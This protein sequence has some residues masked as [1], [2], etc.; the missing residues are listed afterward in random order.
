M[1]INEVEKLTGL[2][3]K[4]IR[5]YESK[6]LIDNIQREAN[7]YRDYS[8]QDVSALRRIKLLRVAGISLADISL[9]QNGVVALEELLEKRKKELEKEYGR[10]SNQYDF[11]EKIAREIREGVYDSQYELEEADVSV[12][13]NL[14]ELLVGLDIGTTSICATVIDIQN[15]RQVEAYCIPNDSTLKSDRPYFAEQD[16]QRILKK[17]MDLLE[18]ILKTYSQVCAIGV[19]GQ[20]HGIVYTD[21]EG[22]AVSPLM[23]W[24]DKRADQIFENG[25]TYCQRIQNL[26]GERIASGYGFATHYYNKQNG[27]VPKTAVSFC[28][29]MDYL[30]MKLTKKSFPLVHASVAASFGLFDERAFCFKKKEISTLQTTG[31]HLPK[32]TEKYAV[33]GC[34]KGIP[35]SVAIGDNQASFLGSVKDP[36]SS[37]LVNIGTGSQISVKSKWMEL[38]G[39]VELRP[40]VNDEYLICGSALCGGYAYAILE[41]FFR[42]YATCVGGADKPQYEIMNELALKAYKQGKN[43]L[44][45]QTTFS[46]TRKDPTLKGGVQGLDEKNFTPENFTLGVLYGMSEELYRFYLDSKVEGKNEMVVSGGGAQR[47]KAL[48]LALSDTFHMPLFLSGNAEESSV[49]AAL[50]AAVA[51]GKL[52]VEERSEYIFYKEE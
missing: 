2:S 8:E 32:V 34:Y 44:R 20:M 3:K 26:T 19:T 28:S 39:D 6:G 7:G 13:I 14:G 10:Y 27:L 43:A 12:D 46:G 29:I 24:Q 1:K 22:N 45:F 42:S 38:R 5:L 40:L 21:K 23:I 48:R 31:I 33:C 50:F 25:E 35:V 17:S 36:E 9:L 4:A 47:N 52:T 16:A 30:V 41:R 15:K 37:V 49:G 11:C 18:H 51:A